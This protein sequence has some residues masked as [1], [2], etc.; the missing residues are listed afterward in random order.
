M[1]ATKDETPETKSEEAENEKQSPENENSSE[2]IVLSELNEPMWSVVSFENS[3][4]NSL[5]YD[6][7]LELMEESKKQKIS[8]LC[9]ITDEAA[10][11]LTEQ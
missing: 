9:I 7:A 8:G 1:L 3:L 4:K 10:Q 5:T 6:E 2:E 11:R